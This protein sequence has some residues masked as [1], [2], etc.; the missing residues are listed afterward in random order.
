MTFQMAPGLG[1]S[2]VV[3]FN[4]H[5]EEISTITV[6]GD[7]LP[8]PAGMP[9]FEATIKDLPSHLTITLPPAEGGT[10]KFDA[11]GDH[12][13]RVYAQAWGAAKAS[14]DPNRQLLSYSDGQFVAA[15]LLGVGSAEVSTTTSP[16]RI[17][18]DIGSQP[19]DYSVKVTDADVQGTIANPQPATV[20][21]RPFDKDV[22]GEGGVKVT[23]NVDPGNH[24]GDGSIDQISLTATIGEAYIHAT[25]DNIPANLDICLQSDEGTLCKPSWTP[26]VEGYTVVPPGFAVH[27]FPRNLS[28]NVP[29]TPVVVNGR[30]CP[31]VPT[32]SGCNSAGQSTKHVVI[33][34]LAF[35]TV[36]AAFGSH[37]EGCDVACGSVW[38][39][40]STFGPGSPSEGDHITGRVRYWDGEDNGGEPL[41]DLNLAAPNDFIALNKLFFFLHYDVVSFTPLV[42]AHS[43]SLTCGDHPHLTIGINNFPDPDVLD[44]TFGVC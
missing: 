16:F 32:A 30:V 10:A 31:D 26:G 44:G 7:G 34:D 8:A 15:N 19:L 17:K 39:E 38:A 2:K 29:A 3:D 4:S 33:E 24:T 41:L 40:A 25:I 12:I 36:E 14:V 28:G 5:G 9:K 21:F 23:Y 13:T 43:G 27:F 11:H 1:G 35:K 6:N 18:Y 20:T 22:D 37:D 42:Y